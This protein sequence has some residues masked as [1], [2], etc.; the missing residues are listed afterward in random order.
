MIYPYTAGSAGVSQLLP[1][2]SL[3]GGTGEMLRRLSSHTDLS[4]F[5]GEEGLPGQYTEPSGRN[6]INLTVVAD[7]NLELTRD[8]GIHCMQN[9]RLA[10]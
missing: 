1:P 4:P 5:S 10:R 8:F 3:E 7:D 9:G 6:L 2:W